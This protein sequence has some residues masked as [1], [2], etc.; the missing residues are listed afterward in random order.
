MTI[1][2]TY[3]GTFIACADLHLTNKRPLNRK[4]DYYS[5]ILNK[6]AQLLG[7][8]KRDSD[9]NL[10]VVAGDFFNSPTVP[11][12]VVIKVM[13]MI[14]EVD[15]DIL[16]VP[17]QHDLRYHVSG[18]DNV[19]LGILDIAQQVTILQPNKIV[20][21]NGITFA[22]AGWDEEP[23]IKSDVLVLHRM[24]TKREPLWEGQKDFSIA[25]KILR[26]YPWAN[27]VISG[28]NHM[29]H[30]FR[31]KGRIQINCG[32]MVRSTKTQIDFEPRVYLVNAKTWKTKQLKYKI[33]PSE[34]VFDFE[35]IKQAVMKQES[36]EK[37]EKLI[38]KFIDTLPTKAKEKPDF[39][40]VLKTVINDVKPNTNVKKIINQIMETVN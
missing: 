9:L 40:L 2:P 31:K 4:G 16:V 1:S 30:T 8:T 5:Q 17:G 35:K 29:P 14:M 6:F 18:L 23:D 21:Y 19:P 37:A 38:A 20:T 27:C 13:E 10:M 33:E 26:K 24:I 22:G 25:G 39:K 7:Y 12:K 32:S 3:D 36:K 28:D 11:Y 34:D 15:V